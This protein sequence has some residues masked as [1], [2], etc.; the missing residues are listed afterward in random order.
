MCVCVR[1]RGASRSRFLLSDVEYVR[2]M[3]RRLTAPG[4][5]E[6]GALKRRRQHRRRRR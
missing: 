6:S 5:R 2:Y 3:R 1:A 4:R